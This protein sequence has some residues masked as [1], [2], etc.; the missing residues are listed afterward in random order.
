MD[1]FE[2]YAEKNSCEITFDS[3]T[4][5]ETLL[6]KG[7]ALTYSEWLKYIRQN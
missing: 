3:E 4:G 2:E 5:E 1:T 7:I 6:C